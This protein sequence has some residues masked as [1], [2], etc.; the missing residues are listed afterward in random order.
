MWEG[1]PARTWTG[2]PAVADPG[3]RRLRRGRDRPPGPHP[4]QHRRRRGPGGPAVLPGGRTG[5]RRAGHQAAPS[6]G[7]PLLGR[8]AAGGGRA[9]ERAGHPPPPPDL[10]PGPQPHAWAGP[11]RAQAGGLDPAPGPGR[12]QAGP[13]SLGAT[14]ND[15][16]MA[17]VSGAFSHY[18]VDHGGAAPSRFLISMPVNVRPGQGPA[19]R[20]PFRPRAPGTARG[21]RGP[22]P[23]HPG[24]E[25]AHGPAQGLRRAHG[26]LPAAA[27]PARLPAPERLSR[28]VIDFL[29][30]KCTAVVTNVSGPSGSSPWPGAGCARCF[31]GAPAGPDRHRHLH[32]ELLRQG[33]GGRHR[34]RGPAAGPRGAGGGLRGEFEALR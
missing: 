18:L 31:L 11:V 2:P 33:P 7:R 27:G 34:R 4:P 24:R 14:V 19:L 23:A 15:V 30:N 9:P 28:G 22:R 12:G 26:D 3:H 25:D 10:A 6:P 13:A 5:Q 29:A 16:L 1:R 20:Q 8:P 21:P 32:P 17:S